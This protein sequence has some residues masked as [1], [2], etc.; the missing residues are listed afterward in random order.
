[1][2]QGASRA[3]CF[4]LVSCLAYSLTLKKEA[5]CR[6]T[7]DGLYDV[8]S[9]KTELFTVTTV[10]TSNPTTFNL[11]ENGSLFSRHNEEVNAWDQATQK[12][13][14]PDGFLVVHKSFIELALLLEDRCQV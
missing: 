11:N 8:I 4:Q 14:L 2:K 13:N 5:T 12:M 6:K 1:M 3:F 9:Q 7:F 10:R